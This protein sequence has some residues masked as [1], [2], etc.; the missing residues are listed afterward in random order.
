MTRVEI[1]AGESLQVGLPEPLFD[2][3]IH[4]TIMRNHYVSDDGRRFLMV[5]SMSRET[6]FPATVVLN[7]DATPRT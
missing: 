7:W 6:I 3:L 2:A 1:E 5:R 4:P